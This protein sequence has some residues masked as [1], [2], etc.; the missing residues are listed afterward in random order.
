MATLHRLRHNQCLEDSFLPQQNKE[1]KNYQSKV[2]SVHVSQ[3]WQP[4]KRSD[5]LHSY[6][7]TTKSTHSSPSKGAH[8]LAKEIHRKMTA[9][10]CPCQLL[11]CKETFST[12]IPRLS[13][14]T[15]SNKRFQ[16][17]CS[18]SSSE[19]MMSFSSAEDDLSNRLCW[20][21]DAWATDSL[22]QSNF[23]H[24]S[25]LRHKRLQCS[26]LSPR[27]PSLSGCQVSCSQCSYLSLQGLNLTRHVEQRDGD[28]PKS[29]RHAYLKVVSPATSLKWNATTSF[30]EEDGLCWAQVDI[31]S[32]TQELRR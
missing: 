32:G 4:T 25:N 14:A 13:C 3:L 17:V 20:T 30:V 8:L 11:V 9:Q 24:R 27:L 15:A 7:R 21:H 28:F 1:N 18:S 26:T 6:R 23:C 5:D 2:A 22:S 12:S 31:K 29:S 19:G 10:P 16:A